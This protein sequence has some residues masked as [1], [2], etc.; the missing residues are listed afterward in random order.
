MLIKCQ[1]LANEANLL[2]LLPSR[3]RRKLR[4]A[5]LTSMDWEP[6]ASAAHLQT[7][8]TALLLND[9]DLFGLLIRR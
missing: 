9:E 6:T 2:A 8:V 5:P 1:K 4:G 7:A 3:T